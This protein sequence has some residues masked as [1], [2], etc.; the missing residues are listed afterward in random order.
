MP[1]RVTAWECHFKVIS[2]SRMSPHANLKRRSPL[3]INLSPTVPKMVKFGAEMVRTEQFP[4][5]PVLAGAA[6]G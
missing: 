6:K 4:A 5:V 1:G 3:T 2:R